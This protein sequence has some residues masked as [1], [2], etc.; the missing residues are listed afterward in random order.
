MGKGRKNKVLKLTAA[1]VNYIIREKTNNISSKIIA[2]DMK[3]SI[4]TV[5][6]VW[7]HWMK[8]KEPLAPKKFGR[9]KKS[10]GASDVKLIL[11]IHKEQNLGARRLEKIIE[12]KHG[13]H[14][15]HNA[16]HK[17]L[18]SHGLANVNHNKSKRRKPWIRYERKH[19]LSMVHLDWHT[20]IHDGKKM[21]VC[22]V[23]D[24][25]S[26]CILAGGEFNAETTDNALQL[27]KEAMDRFG[28]LTSIEQVL[29]DRGTQF[30]ANK[31]DKNG[32]ADSRFEDFLEENKIKHIKARVKHPQTNGKLEKW[33]DTYELNRFRFDNFG[34][35]VNWYNTVRFHESLY[36]KWYLQTQD[37]AFWSRLPEGC[38]LRMFLNRME[39]EL[40]G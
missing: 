27:L 14:I 31:R 8:N 22:A 35:F 21:Y 38:K 33:N 12:F 10:L 26:R 20:S 4:R 19:S 15:P 28:W 40:N 24:D 37:I 30:Y 32:D 25:S 39:T 5:N 29:T 1:K 18:L 2:E 6:R 11:E 16:I 9:P 34:N 3:V 13:K 23:L 36:T 7:G 17:E